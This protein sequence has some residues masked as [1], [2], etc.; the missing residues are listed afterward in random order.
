MVVKGEDGGGDIC[1]DSEAVV[2]FVMLAVSVTVPT[3]VTAH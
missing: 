2:V 3:P 1:N